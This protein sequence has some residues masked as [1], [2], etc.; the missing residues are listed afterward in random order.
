MVDG[1]SHFL[2]CHDDVAPAADAVRVMVEEAFRCNAGIVCPKLVEWDRPE[3]L[4]SVGQSAD[5][6]GVMAPL[7]ER[8]EFD[9][10]QHDAV[11]DVF[12]A[13][14]GCTLVRADLFATLGGYDT[15]TDL[16]GEDLNLSWRAQVAGARVLVAPEA[17]VRHLEALTS[18]RRA[19]W[20]DP[21]APARAE[22]LTEQHRIRTLLTC[23]SGFH[24]VRV[25]PQAIVLTVAEALVRL[26]SGHPRAAAASLTAWG[27]AL[28]QPRQLR[29]AR[30]AVRAHRT[31]PD[32]EV[33]R[34]QTRGSARVRSFLR[35]RLT[36]ERAAPGRRAAMVRSVRSDSWRIRASAWVVVGLILLYGTRGLLRHP[37]PGIGL[38]PVLHHGPAHWW[39]LWLSGWRPDGLGSPAPAPPALALL[40]LA[41]TI[42]FGAVG[43][44]QQ[45][46]VLGPF[47]LGPLGAYRAAR[48]WGSARGQ[49]AALIVYAAVPVPYNALAAGR[50]P[51]LVLYA[52]APWMLAALVR[53]TGEAP[54]APRTRV[55]VRIVGLGL[56]VALTAA[57]VPAALVVVPV[58]GAGLLAGSVL[59]GRP[60]AGLRALAIAVV[61]TGLGWVL[62]FPWSADVVRTRTSLFG[63]APG[64]AGHLGVG[65]VLTFHT[66]PL[67]GS[68]L[69]WGLVLAAALPLVIGRG[70]RLVWAARLWGVAATCFAL[71]WAAGR[72]SIPVPLPTPE[73]LLA[74]AAAALAGAAALGAVAFELD[75][76][77]FRFGWRQLA[78]AVAAVGVV[79]AS[80]PVV[81]ASFGGRWHLPDQQPARRPRRPG[82]RE[83]DRRVP[84]PVGGRPPR[85][86]ARGLVAG[87]RRRVRH[88]G[89]RHAGCDQPVAAPRRRARPPC[90]GPTCDWPRAARRRRSV[91][92]W[93]RS[94]SATSWCP[95]GWRRPAPAPRSSAGRSTCWPGSVSRSTC[96][97]CR[98]TRRSPCTRTRRGRPS[99]RCCRAPPSP[100]A[101][102]IRPRRPR[103][104]PSAG[105]SRSWPVPVPTATR[106]WSRAAGR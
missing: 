33:R 96:A 36:G 37:L 82:R 68:V 23:Y 92:S 39:R 101:G 89:R 40:G 30:R 15:S 22:A 97:P 63:V 71:A 3:R 29:A 53:G 84:G 14:G 11:R 28:R 52:A 49:A 26:L 38:L 88:L 51:G 102:R 47:L 13:P 60:A 50:W 73:V 1:A 94:P 64:P 70:W 98:A 76:S 67:G 83:S 44:V 62:L 105:P 93:R 81:A 90:S 59:T 79:L 19:G 77:G 9:Q 6:V 66:G 72:G 80:L 85:P 32:A 7:V 99:A 75:L 41:G 87:A 2:F 25:L 91:T 58:M 106:V 5:K 20:D 4:L 48:T 43:V 56:I 18:G 54:V 16:L 65:A 95:T 17:R 104:R 24:L 78:P 42:A 31:V 35:G 45:V 86:P 100:P 69:T 27:R 21:G 74:P 55:A 34:L 46:L 103:R 12:F 57:W 8:G 61:A 10:E